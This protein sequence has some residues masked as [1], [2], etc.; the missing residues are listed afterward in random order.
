MRIP[1]TVVLITASLAGLGCSG[2]GS[3]PS[4]GET[5]SRE[6]FVE[7]FVELRTAALR[8]TSMEITLE[9]R[10]RILADLGLTD[11]DLLTFAEVRSRDG[12]LME[13]IW[14]EVDTLL[15]ASRTDEVGEEGEEGDEG[16]EGEDMRGIR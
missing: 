10:D 3:D 8:N 11:E 2:E 12:P 15:R 1:A 9:E 7:A 14:E 6:A 5:I 13:G 4:Q 16:G